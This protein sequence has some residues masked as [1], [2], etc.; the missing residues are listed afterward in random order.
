MVEEEPQTIWDHLD[1]LATRLRRIIIAVIVS[2]F[3]FAVI[4]SDPSR[5]LRLDFNGYRPLV[6]T[7]MELIQKSLLP[8]EVNLIAF[9]WL[10]TFYIYILVSMIFGLVVSLPVIVREI[11]AFLAPAL[12]P[13]EQKY[14]GIFVT[15]FFALFSLGAAYAYFLLLP[16]TFNILYKFVYQTRVIPFFSVKD[17]YNTLALGLIG[18]GIFYT[19]PLIL[20][21]LVRGG[22]MELADLKKNRK[23]LFL[24]IL[25][26]TAVIS[27]DPTP[28]TMFFMTVPFYLIYEITIRVL[29][30]TENPLNDRVVKTGIEASKK[31]LE[32]PKAPMIPRESEDST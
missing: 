10:D 15:I 30:R 24:A 23:Q 17:F 2:T 9:N 5:I 8:E 16:T 27:P 26:L 7:A 25:V 19:F 14:L 18:S 3:I 12:Y 28:F 1:E 22:I 20:Y 11:Y 29:A 13:N 32:R 21:L 4:P 6:M 31:L